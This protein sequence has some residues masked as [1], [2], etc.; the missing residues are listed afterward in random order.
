M[1]QIILASESPRRRE[2]LEKIGL[3]FLV[4]KSRYQERIDP[5]LT[6][7]EL[8]KKLSLGKAKLVAKKYKN[9]IIIAADTFVVLDG[10]IIGKPNDEKNARKTLRLLNNRMHLIITGFTIIDSASK[11]TV[12]KSEETKIYMRKIADHEIDSYIKT[13][14]PLDKA[15]SYAIQEKGSVFIEKIE[16]DYFNAVGLPIYALVKQLKKFGVSVL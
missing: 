6:P 10:K 3:K 8:A 16:G 11:K 5:N 12:S 1:K 2:L 15:G 13:K 7:H 14:E 9:A 4:V